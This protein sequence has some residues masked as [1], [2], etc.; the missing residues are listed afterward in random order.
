MSNA[1]ASGLSALQRRVATT[2][3]SSTQ[4]AA[5]PANP[6]WD[7]YASGL[8]DDNDDGSDGE[9]TEDELETQDWILFQRQRAQARLANAYQREA[10]T[11]R[12]AKH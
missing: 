5:A 4:C 11:L 12:A 9:D 7:F 10:R 8:V 1:S 2:S 3:S 6:F